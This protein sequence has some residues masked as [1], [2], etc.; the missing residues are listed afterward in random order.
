[1][2]E[3]DWRPKHTDQIVSL[4]YKNK[5]KNK[6]KDELLKI[7]IVFQNTSEYLTLEKK[8]FL[9]RKACGVLDL[10]DWRPKEHQIHFP[11][12]LLKAGKV[13]V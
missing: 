5:I 9:Q 13:E 2:E 7:D 12:S 4:P 1:M 10:F 8:I 3:F 6:I 11:T